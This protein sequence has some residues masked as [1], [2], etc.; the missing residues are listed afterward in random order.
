MLTAIHGLFSYLKIPWN[1]CSPSCESLGPK[2][3]F[4]ANDLSSVILQLIFH[5]RKWLKYLR[6]LWR[7]FH[8]YIIKYML[9]RFLPPS[10]SFLFSLALSWTVPLFCAPCFCR[11][12]W[13]PVLPS[14][15]H[16][17]F[18][19]LPWTWV[20]CPVWKKK[21]GNTLPCEAEIHWAKTNLLAGTAG[22]RV[23]L[24]E[25]KRLFIKPPSWLLGAHFPLYRKATA[26][27]WKRFFHPQLRAW[28]SPSAHSIEQ[29]QQGTAC[30]VD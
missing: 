19:W 18:F 24:R 17:R 30:R 13:S 6:R 3:P 27:S 29:R 14:I 22:T 5:T 15:H 23:M 1:L 28:G 2:G 25:Q 26:P 8:I 9:S 7:G 21:P 11:V 16:P 20:L 4:S 12:L 10:S